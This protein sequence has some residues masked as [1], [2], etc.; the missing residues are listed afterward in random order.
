MFS[1]LQ[2]KP[3]RVSLAT[4]TAALDVECNMYQRS[5]G[6]VLRRGGRS[7]KQKRYLRKRRA[8]RK[9]TRYLII[10]YYQALPHH[11]SCNPCICLLKVSFISES[12]ERRS[13]ARRTLLTRGLILLFLFFGAP[14]GGPTR[15]GAKVSLFFTNEFLVWFLMVFNVWVNCL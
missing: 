2:G 5:T 1:V 14:G 4:L 8:P 6:R 10:L 15:Q 7:D 12:C 13:V 3:A 11:P 9:E